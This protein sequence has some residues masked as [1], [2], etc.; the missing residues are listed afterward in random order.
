LWMQDDDEDEKQKRKS[1]T[2]TRKKETA[3]R[4]SA[5]GEKTTTTTTSKMT[6]PRPDKVDQVDEDLTALRQ[7][8][9]MVNKKMAKND[10]EIQK[11]ED[12]VQSLRLQKD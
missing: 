2:L 8:I 6:S 3:A 1:S 11:L 9:Q 10:K 12:C 4:N 7:N 5:R